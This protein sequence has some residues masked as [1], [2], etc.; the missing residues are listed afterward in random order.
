MM[1]LGLYY[2]SQRLYTRHSVTIFASMVILVILIPLTVNY[3]LSV[4]VL[5]PFIYICVTAGIAE[6]L[7]QWFSYFPR[8]PWA[9]NFGISLL[10]IAIGITCFYHLQRFYVAWPNTPETKS[11]YTI[12][13]E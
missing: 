12:F 4:A 6:L 2:F 1:I 11:S 5:L 13:R 10:V 8:N 3:Q 9:R 7:N